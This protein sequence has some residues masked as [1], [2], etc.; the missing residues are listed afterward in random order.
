M[1]RTIP[2][3]VR[4]RDCSFGGKLALAEGVTPSSSVLEAPRSMIELREREQRLK[5]KF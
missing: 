3:K 5:A 2:W 1:I 4:L